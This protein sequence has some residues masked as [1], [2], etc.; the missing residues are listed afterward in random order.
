MSEELSQK[1]GPLEKRCDIR[2][3]DGHIEADCL[4]PED[5]DELARAFEQEAILRVK[6]AEPRED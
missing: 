2:I 6:P 4:T 1:Q 5:R 3:V